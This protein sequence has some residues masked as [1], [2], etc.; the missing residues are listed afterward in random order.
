MSRRYIVAPEKRASL[1]F[2]VSEYSA[3]LVKRV[4]GGIVN[5]EAYHCPVIGV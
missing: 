3:A 5:T 4:C 2:K 1:L